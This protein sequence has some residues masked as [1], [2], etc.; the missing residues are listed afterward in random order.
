MP[1]GD[2]LSEF[3][4]DFWL[5]AQWVLLMIF[6]SWVVITV[7]EMAF[8]YIWLDLESVTVEDHQIGADPQVTAWREIKADTALYWSVTI[9]SHGDDQYIGSFVRPHYS[10]YKKRANSVN[11]LR[12]PLSEWIAVPG[13]LDQLESDTHYRAGTFYAVTCH[14][15]WIWKRCVASAPYTRTER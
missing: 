4:R 7:P 2:A 9:R 1:K 12:M 11:P 14:H 13:A 6:A 8:K 3:L 10:N 5:G 15:K